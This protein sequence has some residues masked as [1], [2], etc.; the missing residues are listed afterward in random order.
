MPKIPSANFDLAREIAERKPEDLK[1]GA[2]SQPSLVSIPE[3][4]RDQYLPIGETQFDLVTDFTDC[5]SRSPVNHLEA[6]FTY[7]FL[8]E[9]KPENKQWFL[10]K[11]YV[12]DAKITFSDRY[13]AQLSGTT[14][15]GNSLKS[16]IETIRTQGLIPK[17][18]LPKTDTMTWE[19]YYDSSKI[20][21]EL[22]NLGQEFLQR[23]TINYEQVDQIHFEEVLKDDMIGVAGYAWDKPVN[24]VYLRKE[25]AAFN[26]AF[27]LYKLPKYQ[28]YDNYFDFTDDGTQIFGD[29]TKNLAPDYNFYDYGYRVFISAEKVPPLPSLQISWLQQLINYL[30]SVLANKPTPPLPP[31]P[32]SNPTPSNNLLNV[33]CLAIQKHEGYVLPGGKYPDGTIA[34]N[35]SVSF[36]CRNPGNVRFYPGGYL[37]KYGTVTESLLGKDVAKGIRGFAIFPSYE[38]GFLYLKN[39]IRTKAIKNPT[40]N[41]YQFF[42]IYAPASD[43]NNPRLYA[44]AVAKAL[45][46]NPATFQLKQLTTLVGVAPLQ[47]N[48]KSIMD[49]Q[50]LS[51]LV[52]LATIA[53]PY[54]GL[55]IST[56]ALTQLIQAVVILVSTAVIWYQRTKLQKAPNGIGDVTSLG[57]AK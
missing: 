3:A 29:F 43:N 15:Q 11:G 8:H 31:P 5:A 53:A 4:E 47:T 42:S 7:H 38:L 22:K 37:P 51:S 36:R 55:T 48:N 6:V 50:I 19:E 56:E 39:L 41:L 54:F 9:M 10:D 23:F 13:I 49:P 17:K 46:V 1:F 14:H 24:G 34:P 45:N 32:M 12:Q 16:P 18:L 35:G 2:L 40:Q 44:E 20:T 26:H 27:L 28:V 57:M 33:M 30:N 25:G 21:P 52:I